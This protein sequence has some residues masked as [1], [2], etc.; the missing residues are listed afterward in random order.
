MRPTPSWPRFGAFS[1]DFKRGELDSLIKGFKTHGLA[2]VQLGSGLLEECIGNPKRATEMKSALNANGIEVVAIAGYRNLVAPDPTKRKANLEFL[3]RAL[4]IAP[5][6]G[7]APVATETGTLNAE[8]DWVSSPA[9][10]GPDAWKAMCDVIAELVAVAETNGSVLALEGYVN[11]VL[12]TADQAAQVLRQFNS[13]HL[14]L[15]LDPYNYLSSDLLPQKESTTA[16]FLN[17]FEN[18]FAIAHL[19]DVGA[20]G[21]EH[22]TPEFGTG[23][24][25]QKMYIEF[26]K[27][28]RPDLPLILEHLPFD[29]IPGAV[30]KV[31]QLIS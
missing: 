10:T 6:L 28:R 1:F 15:V 4:E 30:Q 9:N 16:A 3:K 31:R 26:L 7:N 23:V 13:R 14:Q 24:F 8:S 29:H 17:R 2:A 11:N 12:R 5:H 21:A 19:K 25:P 20:K 18:Q 27:T 22:D